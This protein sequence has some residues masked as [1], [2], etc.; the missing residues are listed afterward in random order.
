M[1]TTKDVAGQT[2]L[3]EIVHLLQLRCSLYLFYFFI[4]LNNVFHGASKWY[5]LQ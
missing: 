2:M 5:T 1:V 4:F 3:Q